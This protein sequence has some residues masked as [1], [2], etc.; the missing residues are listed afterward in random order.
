MMRYNSF[1]I[2]N[3]QVRDAA[4]MRKECREQTK[5][6]PCVRALHRKLW[7]ASLALLLRPLVGWYPEIRQ[8]PNSNWAHPHRQGIYRRIGK[9]IRVAMQTRELDVVLTLYVTHSRCIPL[10]H[11]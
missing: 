10:Q 4:Q 6:S 8:I 11:Y 1:V 7:D 3:K 9:I 2:M 5:C